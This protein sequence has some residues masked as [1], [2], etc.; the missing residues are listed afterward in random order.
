MCDGNCEGVQAVHGGAPKKRRMVS[1]YEIKKAF[2]FFLQ[3]VA[4]K[5]GFDESQNNIL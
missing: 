5:I 4:L 2:F 3:V 1:T